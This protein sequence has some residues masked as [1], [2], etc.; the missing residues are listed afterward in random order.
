MDNCW[1]EVY[2]KQLNIH[3]VFIVAYLLYDPSPRGH[4]KPKEVLL[5]ENINPWLTTNCMI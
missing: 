1:S 4:I 3:I 5:P 2:Q